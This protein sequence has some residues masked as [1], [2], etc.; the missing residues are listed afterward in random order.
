MNK[1]KTKHPFDDKWSRNLPNGGA[2]W[3][4]FNPPPEPKPVAYVPKDEWTTPKPRDDLVFAKSCVSQNWCSTEPGTATVPASDFGKVM[5]VA[6]M[7]VPSSIEA[8]GLAVGFDAVLGSTVIR[9]ARTLK[10]TTV[11]LCSPQTPVSARCTWCSLDLLAA[12]TAIT[13]PRRD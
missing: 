13:R 10:P 1:D 2:S 3:A 9:L 7:P 12:T 4:A 8:V 5:L 6:P 11:F